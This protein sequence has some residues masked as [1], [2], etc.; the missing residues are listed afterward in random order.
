[1]LLVIKSVNFWTVYTVYRWT[2]WASCNINLVSPGFVEPKSNEIQK[3]AL[4]FPIPRLASQEE[5]AQAYVYLMMNRYTTGATIV[6]D[7]GVRFI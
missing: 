7:G 3:Y 1:M 5:I 6:I 2:L 4:Q